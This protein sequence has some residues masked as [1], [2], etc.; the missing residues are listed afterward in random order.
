MQINPGDPISE[1]TAVIRN[2][3]G[4]PKEDIFTSTTGMT[5]PGA[6]FAHFPALPADGWGLGRPCPFGGSIH[7]EGPFFKGYFYRVKA[8]K[9]SDPYISF[10]TLGD[11]FQLER[12]DTGFDPQISTGG[13]FA[14]RDPSQYVDFTLAVWAAGA[15]GDDLWDIQLDI[16]TA[17]NEASI[18]GSTP[19]YRVQLDNTRPAGPPAVPLTMDIH[20]TSG[21]GDCQDTKQGDVI[22]GMFIADDVHFGGWGLSTEPNTVSTPSNQ[23][24]V[25]LLPSTSP[26]PAPGGHAWSLDTG[27]PVSMKPCGYVVRLDVSDRTIVGSMPGQHN[28]NNIEVGFCLRKP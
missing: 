3:G 15:D 24:T 1:P 23:P 7:V 27:S 5:T 13:F 26:A 22:S 4:I 21:F 16:A 28:S 10:K 14:Y 2:I 9:L 11:S 8:H 18:I 17:P 12:W 19:W 6:V 25:T 20:I